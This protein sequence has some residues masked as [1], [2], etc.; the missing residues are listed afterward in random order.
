MIFFDKDEDVVGQ[1]ENGV[2]IIDD[3]EAEFAEFWTLFVS[4]D[5][6]LANEDYY[7]NNVGRLLEL[8]KKH[9]DSDWSKIVSA[10]KLK[11]NV[12]DFGNSL[13]LG[14]SCEDIKIQAEDVS[15]RPPLR[16]ENGTLM[17]SNLFDSNDFYEYRHEGGSFE[18][19]LEYKGHTQGESPPPL[20]IYLYGNNYVFGIKSDVFALNDEVFDDG[21][22][23]DEKV[24]P[25]SNLEAGVY[26]INILVHTGDSR[27][28]RPVDYSMSIEINNGQK[29]RACPKE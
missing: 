19:I 2:D 24:L 28:Y 25:V 21:E 1:D 10:E 27:A 5:R 20:D 23:R 7:F 29:Q 6:G 22:L 3:V 16:N 4:K 14:G 18:L 17:N 8:Q 13:V 12:K 26:M 11:S 9:P 15:G